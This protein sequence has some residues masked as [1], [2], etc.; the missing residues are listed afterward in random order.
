MDSSRSTF[1]TARRRATR[2]RR[3]WS[4]RDRRARLRARGTCNRVSQS[5]A[6]RN[7]NVL[8]GPAKRV[9]QL[10]CPE[11]RLGQAKVAKGDMS[12]RVEQDIF[13]FQVPVPGQHW[14]DGR[15]RYS[16]VYNVILVQML[17]REHEFRHVKPR[18][19]L[20]K[21][22]LLLEMPKEL[23]ATLVIG[24]EEQVLLRLKTKL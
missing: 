23:S 6:T 1:Q 9:G 24:D 10:S 21:P 16:P 13:R 2:N 18:S 19:C 22:A 3:A 7:H 4:T 14:P 5:H 20:G 17:E 11:I 15:S 12:R 8:C